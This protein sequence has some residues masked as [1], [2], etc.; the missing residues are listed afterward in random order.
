MPSNFTLNIIK[1]MSRD[2]AP[3][4]PVVAKGSSEKLNA[5]MGLIESIADPDCAYQIELGG[6]TLRGLKT[7]VG[8]VAKEHGLM[9]L[10]LWEDADGQAWAR[11][12]LQ[13]EGE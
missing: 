7:A 13:G 4:P 12:K 5:I 6:Y 8:R 3:T 1:K 11:Q 2:E 10:E 9:P